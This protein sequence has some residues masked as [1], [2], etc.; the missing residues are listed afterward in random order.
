MST[1]QDILKR[2][3]EV[4]ADEK[5]HSVTMDSMLVDAELDS[6]G[7]MMM[8]AT[9]DSEFPTLALDENGN[10]LLANDLENLSIRDL[11]IKC[12]LLII[13]AS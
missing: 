8:L 4:V 9:L 7:T 2:I 1:K 3:N 12:K 5:G 10:E 13:K 6:L 11:V